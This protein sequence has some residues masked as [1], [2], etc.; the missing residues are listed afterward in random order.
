MF[1]SAKSVCLALMLSVVVGATSASA[2]VSTTGLEYDDGTTVWAGSTPFDNTPSGIVGSIEW[3]VFAPD[4]FP[5][6][7]PDAG[8]VPTAGSYSYVYQLHS[9]GADALSRLTVALV[10]PT[11]DKIGD[12]QDAGNGVS[13]IAPTSSSFDALSAIWF[14]SG[15][16]AIGG[17]AIVDGVTVIL[18]E[19]SS[20]LVFSSLSPPVMSFSN[21]INGGHAVNGLDVPASG[22]DGPGG[23]I[24]GVV[25]E[26]TSMLVWCL[27]TV[28][29]AGLGF[30]RRRVRAA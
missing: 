19:S 26:P 15:E 8:Y 17:T 20:G 18:N 5:F 16:D 21:V 14:F 28:V 27:L 2:S 11:V 9:T 22:E 24:G 12:F 29:G 6:A 7:F 25:P 4:A 23:G 30:R 13:G 10:F 3:A 1:V